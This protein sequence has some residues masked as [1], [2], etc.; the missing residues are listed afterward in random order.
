MPISGPTCAP[1]ATSVTVQSN[2]VIVPSVNLLKARRILQPA[3][4][5]RLSGSRTGVLVERSKVFRI[6]GFCSTPGGQYSANDA[7][8]LVSGHILTP[9]CI[10]VIAWSP[11]VSLSAGVLGD[12]PLIWKPMGHGP[13]EEGFPPLVGLT[14]MASV[15]SISTTR[16]MI[17]VWLVKTYWPLPPRPGVGAM[18]AGAH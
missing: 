13:G 2:P 5:V 1:V 14:T 9:N 4:I 17:G 7:N 12:T 6:F 8:V 3:G 11:A 10:H 18:A 15:M 16:S